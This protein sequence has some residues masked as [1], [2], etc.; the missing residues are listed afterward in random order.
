VVKAEASSS[1][2]FL[3]ALLMAPG[4]T[5]QSQ[6]KVCTVHAGPSSGEPRMKMKRVDV[7]VRVVPMLAKKVSLLGA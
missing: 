5:S 4:K 2:L 3:R 1:L 6:M 7:K